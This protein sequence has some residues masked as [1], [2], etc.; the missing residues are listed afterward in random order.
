MI[1]YV[2]SSVELEPELK[3]LESVRISK[4]YNQMSG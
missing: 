2:L 3:F 4:N 1:Q